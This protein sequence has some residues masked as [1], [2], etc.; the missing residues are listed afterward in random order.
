MRCCYD[1]NTAENDM[2]FLIACI[3]VQL[4]CPAV[5]S[6]SDL[7]EDPAANTQD[8]PA[9]NEFTKEEGKDSYIIPENNYAVVKQADWY[10]VWT[11]EDAAESEDSLNSSVRENDK[12]LEKSSYE[13][14]YSGFDTPISFPEKQTSGVYTVSKNEDGSYTLTIQNQQGELDSGKVSHVGYGPYTGEV[15]TEPSLSTDPSQ[16]TDPSLLTE[17]APLTE[18]VIIPE[19]FNPVKETI[20]REPK[21]IQESVSKKVYAEAPKTGDVT[22]YL[23]VLSACSAAGLFVLMELDNRN[24]KEEKT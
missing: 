23:S 2:D 3:C 10:F 8:A 5:V 16:P 22:V 19:P 6:A 18:S 20:P 15:T 4:L 21:K 11:P 17:P 9:S 14:T 24:K 7:P 1:E 12:S 13:G